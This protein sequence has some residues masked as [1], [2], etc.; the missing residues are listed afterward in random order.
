MKNLKRF[1]WLLFY[2]VKS[3]L[4]FRRNGQLVENKRFSELEK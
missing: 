3:L 1:S 4:Y 2:I